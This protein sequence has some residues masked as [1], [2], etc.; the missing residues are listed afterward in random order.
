MQTSIKVNC[1]YT[2]S[3]LE[4]VRWL[5]K[6]PD[7]IAC[8]FEAASK[9]T[10]EQKATMQEQYDD[11]FDQGTLEAH[12][13]KQKIDSDG[14]SHPSL[15]NIT[16]FSLAWSEQDSMVFITDTPKMKS[17]IFNWLVTTDIKQIWHNASFDFQH[18]FYNT[19]G[20][21][22]KDYEDSQ[23]LAKTILNHVNNFKSKV[24]LKELMGYKYGSWA[25]SSD[26]FQL[27]R[28]YDED[29]IHY[30]G[31]DACATYALW[32]E[33]QEFVKKEKS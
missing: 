10:D 22:P 8:D 14:L 32:E 15:A 4:A 13:L 3:P 20:S 24:G 18:I 7:T 11:L 25:V 16:H 9:Y 5:R 27:S 6:L 29:V 23:V 26:A 30:A 28:M 17:I 21:V 33:M 1:Q 31:V 12:Q 19:G 2:K